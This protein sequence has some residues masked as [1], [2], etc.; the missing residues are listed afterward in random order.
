MKQEKKMGLFP[1]TIE[2]LENQEMVLVKG[3]TAPIFVQW[4]CVNNCPK[5]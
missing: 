1:E 5:P 4:K 2:R 3:G